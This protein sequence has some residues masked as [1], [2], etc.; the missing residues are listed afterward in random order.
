VAS[1]TVPA[2]GAI[3]AGT[4]HARGILLAT[5][6]GSAVAFLDTTVVNVALPAIGRGLGADLGG[7]QWTVDAYLLTLTAFLLPGGALGDRLGRR[8]VFLAGLVAF[9]ATSALCAATTSAAQL[10]AARL[11]QGIAAALLVPGS[12]AILRSSFRGEDEGRAVGAWAALSGLTTALGPVAGGWLAAISW[13]AIFLVNVPL[14]AAAAWATLR[15]VPESRDPTRG[16]ADVAGAVLAAA[17]LGGMVAALVGAAGRGATPVVLA[18]G[19]GGAVALAAFLVVEARREFPMLPLALFR[20]RTFSAVNALTLAVYFGLNGALF[21]FVLQLQA[22]LG[23]SPIAS[24]AALLPVTALV[25][26]LSPVAGRLAARTGPR[27]FLAAGPSLIA[28]GLWWLGGVGPG[29]TYAADVLPG[30]LL[31]GAGLGAT[32]APLTSAALDAVPRERAGIASGVNNAVARLAALLAVAALPL[33]GGIPAEAVAKGDLGP[34]YRRALGIA[35]AAAAGGALLALVTLR[36]LPRAPARRRPASAASPAG[37]RPAPGRRRR[38]R[39]G[40]R[41]RPPARRPPG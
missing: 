4:P 35:A 21:L 24:G 31:L 25:S 6:L 23:W 10:A 32:V 28:A 29:A 41:A 12:L 27:L 18:A 13:R 37:R 19:A 34:G 30:V 7:L 38:P 17:G 40:A 16:P 1:P 8:R 11:A 2:P 22:G 36:P 15:C 9:G 20:S 14:I 39:R 3:A 26:S 5:V 33:A